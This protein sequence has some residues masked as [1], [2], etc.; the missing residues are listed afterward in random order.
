MLS[1]SLGS[2]S[3]CFKDYFISLPLTSLELPLQPPLQLITISLQYAFLSVS[4]HFDDHYLK[5]TNYCLGYLHFVQLG[6]IAILPQRLDLIYSSNF[7]GYWFFS[8]CG[9]LAFTFHVMLLLFSVISSRRSK[10]LPVKPPSF[11]LSLHGQLLRL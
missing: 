4:M 8:I 5:S 11:V 3:Q 1:L 7:H 6:C 10:F 2:T 9:I